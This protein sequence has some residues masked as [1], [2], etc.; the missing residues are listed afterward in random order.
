MVV[1][2]VEKSQACWWMGRGVGDDGELKFKFNLLK[3]YMRRNQ[4]SSTSILFWNNHKYKF[5]R[6]KTIKNGNGRFN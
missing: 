6:I 3:I 4:R 2:W 5:L 1:C